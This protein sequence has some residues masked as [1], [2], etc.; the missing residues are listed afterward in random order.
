MV[1]KIIYKYPNFIPESGN[2]TD[3]IK[4]EFIQYQID[5]N[6]IPIDSFNNVKINGLVASNNPND[7]IYFWQLYSILGSD[8][9]HILI[10]R[11][12]ENIFNDNEAD[13]FRDE[14]IET[15]T[16][17]Y[18]ILG[19]KKFWIDVMGGGKT[20]QGSERKLKLRHQLVENI[21]TFEG[22]QRWMFHMNNTLQQ[23]NLH[24]IHDIRILPCIDKFLHFFMKKYSIE[25]D[26]NLYEMVKK[27]KSKL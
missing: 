23:L 21:M 8:P 14:F 2:L 12:Y 13:W 19:Q 3:T 27:S 25:F 15:G 10:K 7:E 16:I 1:N 11:F 4:K 24:F 17:E 6:I 22:S 5:L 26:F 20:Y 9:I 18:H